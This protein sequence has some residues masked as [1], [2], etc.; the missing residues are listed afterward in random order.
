MNIWVL[1]Y[2]KIDIIWVIPSLLDSREIN[3][4]EGDAEEY[5]DDR[6]HYFNPGPAHQTLPVYER[7]YMKRI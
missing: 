4:K 5:T 2:C 7:K 6:H 3:L 1:L